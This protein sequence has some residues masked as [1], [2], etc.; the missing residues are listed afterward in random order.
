ML[1]AARTFD[2]LGDHALAIS[3]RAA[4]VAAAGLLS[5]GFFFSA[6][7]DYK[8]WVV[9]ALGPAGLCVAQRRVDRAALV[10]ATE[11]PP[12]VYADSVRSRWAWVAAPSDEAPPRVAVVV[13]CRDD[14][15]IV[16]DALTTLNRQERCEVV[17]VDGGSTDQATVAHLAELEHEGVRVI[18][19]STHSRE[20]AVAAGVAATRARYII[21]LEGLDG[22]MPGALSALADVL[23]R[24]A[25]VAAVWGDQ[26]VFGGV[27]DIVRSADRLDPW[28]ITYV[29]DLPDAAL[30]RRE[31][32]TA[33][34]GHEGSGPWGMW[35]GMAAAGWM[36][37]REPIVTHLYRATPTRLARP[38]PPDAPPSRLRVR[39]PGLYGSRRWNW[40]RS[41]AP[42]KARLLY[43][44]IDKLPLNASR[45]QRM[46]ESVSDIARPSIPPKD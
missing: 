2:R 40:L 33:L 42:M 21:A 17:I 26:R 35:A 9:L 7:V 37:R 15:W 22:L 38:S 20:A 4:F 19:L 6:G 29:N 27:S 44:V 28:K 14:G 46:L 25:R 41:S 10:A 8:N 34:L 36:A 31:A 24:D 23:D 13:T 5:A 43:P 18:R 3:C 1:L 39:Y 45:R 30:L 32:A 11:P 16:D 12:A